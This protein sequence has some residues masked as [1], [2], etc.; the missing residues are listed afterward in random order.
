LALFTTLALV[1][2]HVPAHKQHR[3]RFPKFALCVA[4]R[5]SGEPGSY[6][7]D[8]IDWRY[9]AEGYEGAANWLNATWLAAGG[10]RYAQHAYAATPEQ[11][12]KVFMS[13]EPSHPGAWP[14]SVPP[15][16]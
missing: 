7:F 6:R 13:Y 14:Q 16:E 3:Y 9:D 2:G 15:C 10:G 1:A 8:T 11:Q 4:N 5:E 12:V